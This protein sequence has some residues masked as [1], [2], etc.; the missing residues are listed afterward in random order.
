MLCLSRLKNQYIDIA[1]GAENGGVTICVL[2][3]RGDKV[4]LAFDAHK[5]I[6]IHRREVQR[7]VDRDSA[8]DRPSGDSRM[9]DPGVI[10]PGIQE[11]GIH[12]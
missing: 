8:H 10:G 6:T 11:P 2:D 12:E 5:D 3:I 7:R 4:R 1:G 9:T